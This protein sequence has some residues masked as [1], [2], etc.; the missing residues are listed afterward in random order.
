MKIDRAELAKHATITLT[1]DCE[2]IPVRGNASAIDA[3]TDRETEDEIF[4]QLDSGNDW[5]WCNVTVTAS[6]RGFE[7]SDHLG[8]CSYASEADFRACDYFADMVR[9]ALIALGDQ[10]QESLDTLDQLM[11]AGDA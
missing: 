9:S 10:I 4:R 8:A 6:F 5:A 11:I 7:A 2:D 3:E 1:H